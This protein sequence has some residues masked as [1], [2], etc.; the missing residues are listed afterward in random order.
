MEDSISAIVSN[1]QIIFNNNVLRIVIFCNYCSSHH[2]S[3][4]SIIAEIL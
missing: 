1:L 2:C 4:N 3:R